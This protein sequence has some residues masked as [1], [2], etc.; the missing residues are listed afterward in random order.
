MCVSLKLEDDDAMMHTLKPNAFNASFIARM[1]ATAH[2]SSLLS[3]TFWTFRTLSA[4]TLIGPSC[5]RKGTYLT[6][7]VKLSHFVNGTRA[8]KE[9]CESKSTAH[10]LEDVHCSREEEE[11]R[12]PVSVLSGIK[13]GRRRKHLWCWLSDKHGTPFLVVFG[14]R[15]RY[16]RTAQPLA[17]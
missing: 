10:C 17:H 6:T 4:D 9:A 15:V 11:G 5:I 3:T 16:N 12:L 8:S 7:S 2:P 13:M 1:F 14:L